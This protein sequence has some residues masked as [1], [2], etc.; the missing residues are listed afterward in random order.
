VLLGGPCLASLCDPS[1]LHSC[2]DPAPVWDTCRHG[3]LK[4]GN[5][6]LTVNPSPGNSDGCPDHSEK[7][8]EVWTAA[9]SQ[10]LSA[11][12]ADFG[13]AMPLGPKD[14]HATM[15]ARGVSQVSGHSAG[16]KPAL[17]WLVASTGE[18][19][20]APSHHASCQHVSDLFV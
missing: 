2:A 1:G 4:A 8:V 19:Q 20:Q 13:M 9:G 14:T 11:K 5:V 12:V 7:C 10:P 6:L 15:L 16:H 18:G 17:C 3:D